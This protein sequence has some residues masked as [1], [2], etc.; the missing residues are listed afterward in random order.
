MN[1]PTDFDYDLY[2]R[3]T[4]QDP[5]PAVKALQEAGP[6]L[7]N[8]RTGAYM[9]TTDKLARTVLTDTSRFTLEGS[10]VQI[11]FGKEAFFGID[12]K[13]R[14]DQLRSIWMR[15]FARG[16]LEALRPMITELADEM[17]DPVEER[18]RA[19]EVVDLE[20]ELCRSLPAYV[21]AHMMGVPKRY[22]DDV[23]RWSDDLGA[24]SVLPSNA[25]RETDP[26]WI[27]AHKAREEIGEY[28]QEA[29]DHRRANP[30]GTDLISQIVHSTHNL[31]DEVV[32]ANS[33]QMLYA[34]NE[35]T[36]KWLGH[37]T[38]ALAEHPDVRRQLI[39]DPK[40]MAQAI[41]EVMRWK[42]V[43]MASVRTV[44]PGGADIDGVHVPEGATMMPMVCCANRDPARYDNPDAFDIYRKFQTNLGFGFGMHS[45]LGVTLARLETSI[46]IERL[47]ARIP[48]Y[49]L[50]GEVIYNAF[51]LRGPK[52]LP[53]ALH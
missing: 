31:P 35:T 20:K 30:G 26:T 9:V 34:G 37:I 4:A 12:D 46:V 15:A 18:L 3:E 10:I 21:I 49:E 27:R 7:R 48:D 33:R 23:V 8:A 39:E 5:W 40:L 25:S 1:T 53:I 11:R 16:T 50:A 2:S 47:L 45:C 6:V 13:A 14:H 29:I 17:L 38:V 51:V 22:R 43:V 52:V 24:A 41:E 42:P 19:G 44:M 28:L 36:A 32:I